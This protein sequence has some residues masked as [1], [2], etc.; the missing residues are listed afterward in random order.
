MNLNYK[1]TIT[2]SMFNVSDF[3]CSTSQQLLKRTGFYKIIWAREADIN[4]TIDSYD[5][6]F[7]KSHVLFC[8][9]INVVTID[10]E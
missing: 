9:P 5:F 2:E 1:T 4:L 8:T 6:R 3:N 7:S 10:K